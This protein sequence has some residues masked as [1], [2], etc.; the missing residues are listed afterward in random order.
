ME[1]EELKPHVCPVCSGN[2]LV[3]NGFYTQTS[4]TWLTTSITPEPCKSCTGTGIVWR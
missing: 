4:G 2:G 3:P 1:R